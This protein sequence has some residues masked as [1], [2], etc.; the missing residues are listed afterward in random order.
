MLL[1][2]SGHITGKELIDSKHEKTDTAHTA[3]AQSAFFLQ[4]CVKLIQHHK[5]KNMFTVVAAREYFVRETDGGRFR[6]ISRPN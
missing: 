6:T 2:Q 5:S 4:S 3:P 1:G